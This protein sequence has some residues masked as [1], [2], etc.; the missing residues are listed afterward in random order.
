[1]SFSREMHAQASRVY[2]VQ[3]ALC[4]GQLARVLASTAIFKD[5]FRC[6]QES[7]RIALETGEQLKASTF[8]EASSDRRADREL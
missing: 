5:G 7:Q 2:H 6:L 8:S 3:R 1:M 4:F